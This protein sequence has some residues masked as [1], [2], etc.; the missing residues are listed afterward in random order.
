MG[1]AINPGSVDINLEAACQCLKDRSAPQCVEYTGAC[2]TCP[3]TNAHSTL[4]VSVEAEGK[5]DS[6]GNKDARIVD[7]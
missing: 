4:A 6:R 5:G 7:V 1:K 3:Y 2:L